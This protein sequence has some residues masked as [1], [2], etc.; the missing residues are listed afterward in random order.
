M[1]EKRE[2]AQEI[3]NLDPRHLQ[4]IYSI[5]KNSPQYNHSSSH[6]KETVD[7]SKIGDGGE[8][9]EEVLGVD[10]EKIDQKSLRE[11]QNYIKLQK[12]SISE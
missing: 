10:L 3:R 12:N 9:G 5:I 4:R 11:L 6:S 7:E 2:I 1:K 8:G